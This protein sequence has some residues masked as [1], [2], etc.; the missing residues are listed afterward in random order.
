MQS[1]WESFTESLLNT[2]SAFVISW[3]VQAFV[4]PFIWPSVQASPT[5][6]LGIVLLFTVVAILRN[7]VWRRLFNKR[8]IERTSHKPVQN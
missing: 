1:K 6:A 3:L 2:A 7:Y 4:V 8:V 5:E